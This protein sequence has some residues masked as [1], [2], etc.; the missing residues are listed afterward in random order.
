MVTIETASADHL[1]EWAVL[2]AQLWG[3][4]SI[5]EHRAEVEGLLAAPY[6]DRAAFVAIGDGGEVVGFAEAAIRRDYVNGCDT[7]PVAFLE[8]IYVL[9][10]HRHAGVARTVCRAV[11]E[12]G[13][14]AG[15]TELASDADVANGESRAFHAAIGFDETERVV[16]FRKPI[17]ATGATR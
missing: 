7:S 16:F 2:R 12:W 4:E 15:C 1:E 5:E 17:Q 6:R 8:G 14:A 13:Q 9:P 3:S 11:E 10:D